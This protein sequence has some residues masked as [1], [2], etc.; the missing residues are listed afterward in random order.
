M[1]KKIASFQSQRYW[2]F[3]NKVRLIFAMQ[4][5]RKKELMECNRPTNHFLNKDDQV[6]SFSSILHR[7][8]INIYFKYPL[9]LIKLSDHSSTI[10]IIQKHN[11]YLSSWSLYSKFCMIFPIF[12][13]KDL[14]RISLLSLFSLHLVIPPCFKLTSEGEGETMGSSLHCWI[15]PH[16]RIDA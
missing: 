7:Y 1:Q 12:V 14:R 2:S 13:V 3:F 5:Y 11:S 4:F 6:P 15:S 16:R 8:D 10:L 9:T